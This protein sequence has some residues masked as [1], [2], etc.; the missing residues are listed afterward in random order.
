MVDSSD[1]VF[2]VI[3]QMAHG[4][5]ISDVI[6]ATSK[7]KWLRSSIMLKNLGLNLAHSL[8][9]SDTHPNMY[10]YTSYNI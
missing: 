10:Y 6:T 2:L 3:H 5:L 9:Y 4:V 7:C 8:V 1:N